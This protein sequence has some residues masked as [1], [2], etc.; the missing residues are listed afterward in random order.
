MSRRTEGTI[1]SPEG[2][3]AMLAVSALSADL[4]RLRE[5]LAQGNWKLHE[6]SDCCEGNDA[7]KTTPA[8]RPAPTC[9]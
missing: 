8:A 6:T 9:A 5:I 4:V 2:T 7:R 3:A 1:P